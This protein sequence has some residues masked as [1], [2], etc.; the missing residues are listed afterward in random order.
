GLA[1]WPGPSD[2]GSWL[3]DPPRVSR[4]LKMLTGRSLLR[5]SIYGVGDRLREMFG[6]LCALHGDTPAEDKTRHAVNSGLLGRLGFPRDPL[7]VVLASEALPHPLGIE[8]A[9]SRAG[10]QDV[11]VGQLAAL[12][13]L[14][15]HH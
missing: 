6:R 7:D 8:G 5:L 3:R 1:E 9:F 11:A 15:L 10:N 4:S 14:D 12:A 13:T 2:A